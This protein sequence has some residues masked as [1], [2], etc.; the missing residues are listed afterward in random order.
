MWLSRATWFLVAGSGKAEAVARALGGAD[1]HE[2][3]ATGAHGTEETVW[4]LDA[5][6]AGRLPR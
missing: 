2:V 4:F 1:V 3:P 6:A 5:A